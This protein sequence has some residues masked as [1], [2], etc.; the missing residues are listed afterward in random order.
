M[1]GPLP[2]NVA[3]AVCAALHARTL[4][5]RV[6]LRLSGGWTAKQAWE[7]L[8]ESPRLAVLGHAGGDERHAIDLVYKALVAAATAGTVRR[9]QVK[10]TM[11]LNTKGPRDMLVDV[12]RA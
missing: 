10:Y 5:E 1:T 12:F 4:A 8:A 6:R 7:R 9:Q 3:Q 2:P 11:R